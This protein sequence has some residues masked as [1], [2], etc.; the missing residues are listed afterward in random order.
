MSTNGGS[1]AIKVQN[2][3]QQ[4]DPPQVEIVVSDT[5]PG[6]PEDILDHIFEP[7]ISNSPNGTGLGLAITKRIITAHKGNV[8]VESYPGGTVF[9]ILLPAAKG[10]K[11]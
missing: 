6:I 5:G 8:N 7:F 4:I 2:P 3:Q 9:H 10:E 11:A 1:L